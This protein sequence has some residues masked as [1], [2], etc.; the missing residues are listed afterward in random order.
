MKVHLR[1][2][3]EFKNVYQNGKRYDSSVITAF[4]LPNDQPNHRLG[5][6]VSRKTASRALDRN[7]AKRLLR[8][9]FRI[10]KDSLAVLKRKYDWVLNGKRSLVSV[11]VNSPLA[12]FDKI[13]I[14]V[15]ADEP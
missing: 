9:T 11:K 12:E 7:R 3:G 1:R 6:T 15:A 10:R 4:V 14:K 8:E 2:S 5:I 13:M